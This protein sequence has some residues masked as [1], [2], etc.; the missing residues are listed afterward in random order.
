MK[1]YHSIETID[2]KEQILL[3]VEYPTE[4]EFS[5]DFDSLKKNVANVADKIREYALKNLG[6]IS[7]NT[8]LLIL[9]GVV[10]GTLMLT[11]LTTNYTPT[12]NNTE[13]VATATEEESV[14]TSAKI[15]EQPKVEETT[16]QEEVK[17]EEQK[18][19]N[20]ETPSPNQNTTASPSKTTTQTTKPSTS[21]SKNT[22]TSN[23]TSKPSSSGSNS[24]NSANTS[25]GIQPSGK[26]VN[27]K[28]ASGQIINIDLEEYVLGVVAAEMPAEFHNEALKAQAVAS[29]TYALKRTASGGT[30]SATVSDQVYQTNAQ[31]K[32]KWGSSY[33]K[34]YNKIKNAVN[35]TRGQCLTYNGSY[36]E[37]LFFST[38]N[39]K[40]E[41]PVYVWGNSFPY[42]KSVD[43]SWDKSVSGFSQSKSIP[44]S[45]VSSKLGVNI[46]SIS[47]IKIVSKTAGDRVKEVTFCGKSF[48][49][50]KVRQLLGLRSADFDISQNGNNIVFTTRGYG[51]GVGMSQYGANGMAKSGSSYKQILQHYYTGVS[52]VTK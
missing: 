22:G 44:I 10:V 45:T 18:E 43:S 16:T 11:K 1:I 15:E 40:T 23:S 19:E 33:D 6:G 32:Q 21:T 31:L 52:F 37:A 48:T 50:V 39:G 35:A 49:G 5:L 38:S 29:R 30:L 46:S 27:V 51:H 12:N 17:Q 8:A 14:E 41:E 7:D 28:L 20:K 34:Y 13:I 42:L 36:I 25:T 4:Y 2:G 47:D 9:N 3:F 26:T 24:S